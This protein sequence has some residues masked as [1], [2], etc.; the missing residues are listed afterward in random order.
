MKPPVRFDSQSEYLVQQA[1]EKLMEG[2][3]S[4]IIAHRLSTIK[5]VDRIFVI[6]QG[7][8]AEMG[9]HAELTRVN[10]GLYSNL[11]KMQLHEQ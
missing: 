5:K 1:L 3:T 10:N 11:L 2:R 9:S 7:Q 8:L 4:I 6:N